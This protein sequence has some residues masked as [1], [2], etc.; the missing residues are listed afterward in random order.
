MPKSIPEMLQYF[1]SDC[2]QWD[3][4]YTIKPMMGWYCIYKSWKIFAIY[5]MDMI[6]FKTHKN[7]IHDFLDAWTKQFEFQKKDGKISRMNYYI[8]PEEVFENSDELENW[9]EKALDY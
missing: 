4:S 7:N 8:L 2:L 5:A 9:I 3:T 1:L 6:Y